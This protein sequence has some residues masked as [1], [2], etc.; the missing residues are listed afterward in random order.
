VKPYLLVLAGLALSFS[1]GPAFALKNIEGGDIVAFAGKS[2]PVQFTPGQWQAYSEAIAAALTPE[3]APDQMNPRALAAGIVKAQKDL[4]EPLKATE[5][6]QDYLASG[7][8]QVLTKLNGAAI[9]ALLQQASQPL[10]ADAAKALRDVVNAAR[11]QIDRIDRTA[12]F[13]SNRDR[14]LFA[15]EYYGFIAGTIIA[16]LPP[17][18]RATISLEDFGET[19]LCKDVGR[20][21]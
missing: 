21:A 1:A 2:A 6:Y 16:F 4:L 11:T 19:V 3:T 5:A 8:C 15:A 7:D 10:S 20:T 13:R 17:E 18:K 12:R 9:D 14:T